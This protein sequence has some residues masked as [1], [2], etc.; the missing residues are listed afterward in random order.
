MYSKH[1][2][3]T[4]LHDMA[5]EKARLAGARKRIEAVMKHLPPYIKQIDTVLRANGAYLELDLTLKKTEGRRTDN[6]R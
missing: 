2:E 6:I 4:K 3:K 1:D 5:A